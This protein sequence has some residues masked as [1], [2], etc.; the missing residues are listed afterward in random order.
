[1]D[2]LNGAHE[3]LDGPLHRATLAGNLRDLGRINRLL[4][5]TTL[6]WRALSHV[7]R[8]I[9]ADR[10]VR[11]LD[12]GTG[13]ADIPLALVDR[14][15]R[16]GRRLEVAATDVRPEIVNIARQ[17]TA[18]NDALTVAL[19][20]G[21][22]LAWPD[23]AFDIVHASLLLHHQDKPAAVKQLRELGRVA[24]SAVIVNDLQRS[25]RWWIA[26]WLLTRIAT[27]NRY[28]RHDAPLSV[29]RAYTAD[30]MRSLASSAGLRESRRFRD[31]LGHRY[32]LVLV[33]DH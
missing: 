2:R 31:L 29:R 24:R 6:S 7:L 15:R 32:A 17:R 22:R 14:A 13:G 4:G 20:E 12:V 28:T 26:A 8:E 3:L 19:V 11:L 10:I 27:G 9:P 23:G 1:V 25:R 18:G 33:H 5:G 30:E 16:Y 21:R